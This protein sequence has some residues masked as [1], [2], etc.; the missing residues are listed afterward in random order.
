MDLKPSED[1]LNLQ[2]YLETLKKVADVVLVDCSETIQYFLRHPHSIHPR[3]DPEVLRTWPEQLQ[4]DARLLIERRMKA[5]RRK[6]PEKEDPDSQDELSFI[7]DDEN[8]EPSEDEL[9]MEEVE[10]VKRITKRTCYQMESVI[11]S[12][13]MRVLKY[14]WNQNQKMYDDKLVG[15][16][17]EAVLLSDGFCWEM[18][19]LSDKELGFIQ[20]LVSDRY[21]KM[22][23]LEKREMKQKK[24]MMEARERDYWIEKE[25]A[26]KSELRAKLR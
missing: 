23:K 17:V 5:W 16:V 6:H 26:R 1:D 13:V 9:T 20:Q 15:Q 10:K 4:L 14:R 12:I 11:L 24:M 8:L 19:V 18:D 2:L 22:K 3:W 25:K 21:S 7:S